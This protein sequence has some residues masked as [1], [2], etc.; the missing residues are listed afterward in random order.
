MFWHDAEPLIEQDVRANREC[1]SRPAR[2]DA[3]A[4]A[5]RPSK[6]TD[7]A[8][9]AKLL[10]SVREKFVEQS[11]LEHPAYFLAFVLGPQ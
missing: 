3:T 1:A 10:G 5:D 6:T 11:W 4:T 2:G 8:N 7:A 9:M